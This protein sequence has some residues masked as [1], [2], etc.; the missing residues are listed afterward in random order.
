MPL[1][2][3]YLCTWPSLDGVAVVCLTSVRRL[4]NQGCRKLSEATKCT[5]YH[6]EFSKRRLLKMGVRFAGYR[7]HCLHLSVA[8]WFLCCLQPTASERDWAAA[9]WKDKGV[10]VYVPGRY[11]LATALG[12]TPSCRV[13]DQLPRISMPMHL[14]GKQA[15]GPSL[16]FGGRL[17]CAATEAALAVEVELCKK[18]KD[19]ITAGIALYVAKLG[20]SRE[21]CMEENGPLPHR[22]RAVYG[23]LSAS[24][25]LAPLCV[26]V[27]TA[28][29]CSAASCATEAYVQ[30]QNGNTLRGT[31]HP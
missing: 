31:V 30:M 22:S 1:S 9:K 20:R 14:I 16:G 15:A 4:S 6:F 25:C 3:A 2:T 7:H 24:T 19:C 18:E 26:S 13:A 12:C 29:M 28:A 23:G 5:L 11:L 10:C 27:C 8:Y 17:Q 21:R